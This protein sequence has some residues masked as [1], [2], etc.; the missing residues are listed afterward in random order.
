MSAITQFNLFRRNNGDVYIQGGIFVD[1]TRPTT[2]AYILAYDLNGIPTGDSD[3]F[4]PAPV[5]AG[6]S[7]RNI[8]M[9]FSGNPNLPFG[10]FR[11]ISDYKWTNDSMPGGFYIEFNQ[12]TGNLDFKNATGTIATAPLGSI[13]I[14]NRAPASAT[15]SHS[16]PGSQIITID[17]GSATGTTNFTY[18]SVTGN[19]NFNVTWNGVSRFSGSGSGTTSFNKNLASPTTATVEVSAI[20]DGATST[21]NL[22]VPGGGAA[23]YVPPALGTG[24]V[25]FVASSTSYGNSLN[26]GV[27]FNLYPLFEN[28]ANIKTCSVTA[29]TSIGS[30]FVFNSDN[31]QRFYDA[32]GKAYEIVIG[33]TQAEFRDSTDIIAVKDTSDDSTF[34]D[35]TG[36]YI[37]TTYGKT[38]YSLADDFFIDVQ[39]NNND[40]IPAVYF[41]IMKYSAGVFVGAE[42]PYSLSSLPA[43]SATDKILPIGEFIGGTTN[44]L[45][46]LWEGPVLL[47]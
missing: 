13:A 18:T 12:S 38:K 37:S 44:K 5:L 25:G 32:T 2:A 20:G 22:G 28:S 35:P 3:S 42:G 11:P 43:N 24:R 47:R 23:P 30:S 9:P 17:L 21:F 29:E 7:G 8:L 6:G 39:H 16:G 4:N 15:V 36:T 45:L 14:N 27:A 1:L 33:Q 10:V 41:Y 19:T 46:Q 26:G 34:T 31:Y 40:P